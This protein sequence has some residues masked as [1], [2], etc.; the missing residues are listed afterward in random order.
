MLHLICTTNL[1]NCRVSFNMGCQIFY[2]NKLSSSPNTPNNSKFCCL[3]DSIYCLINVCNFVTSRGAI[4]NN[5]GANTQPSPPSYFIF[6]IFRFF[7][8]IVT[9]FPPTIYITSAPNSFS[10]YFFLSLH[11][12]YFFLGVCSSILS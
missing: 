5:V 3:R 12:F 6:F 7:L 4:L 2:G 9:Y 8:Y 10:V 11:N 1:V